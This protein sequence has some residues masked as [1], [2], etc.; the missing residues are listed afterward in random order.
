MLSN[1]HLACN[2]PPSTSQLLN[3]NPFPPS[4]YANNTLSFVFL[5]TS[6]ACCLKIVW[7]D[8]ERKSK[9]AQGIRSDAFLLVLVN[10]DIN[11]SKMNVVANEQ[12]YDKNK[13]IAMRV[14][15][16]Q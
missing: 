4:S 10:S 16:L 3:Y 6:S 2:F 7:K 5:I 8:D 9:S 11:S 12:Q 15:F 13:N 14:M 1:K